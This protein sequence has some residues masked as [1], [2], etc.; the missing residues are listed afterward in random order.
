[1]LPPE[2]ANKKSWKPYCFFVGPGVARKIRRRRR[3]LPLFFADRSL[4]LSH[5]N[6]GAGDI[7]VRGVAAVT[8]LAC[9]RRKKRRKWGVWGEEGKKQNREKMSNRDPV[10]ATFITSFLQVRVT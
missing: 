6:P 8:L 10:I 7:K 5:I 4:P 3:G 9:P 2:E 1:M